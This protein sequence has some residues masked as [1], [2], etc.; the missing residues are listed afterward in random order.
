LNKLRDTLATLVVIPDARGCHSDEG[1][2]IL[3][4]IL[5]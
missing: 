5:N 3:K 4:M 2:I 1:R